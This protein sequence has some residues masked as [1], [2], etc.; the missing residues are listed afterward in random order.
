MKRPTYTMRVPQLSHERNGRTLK[1]G[2][3]LGGSAEEGVL[4]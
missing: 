2:R 3:L 4:S 1:K